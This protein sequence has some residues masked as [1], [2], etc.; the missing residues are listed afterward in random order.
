MST[1]SSPSTTPSHAA[2]DEALVALSDE[3]AGVLRPHDLFGRLG[4]D[5]FAVLLPSCNLAA[6]LAVVERLKTA[7]AAH[8]HPMGPLTV[9]VGAAPL[10]PRQELAHLLADADLALIEAKRRGRNRVCVSSGSAND[11]GGVV[12]AFASVG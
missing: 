8:R 5:E 11:G 1:T 3:L 4:G 7:V 12:G 10:R 9:S 6:A 2:G